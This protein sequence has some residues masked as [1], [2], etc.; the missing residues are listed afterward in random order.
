MSKPTASQKGWLLVKDSLNDI[1]LYRKLKNGYPITITGSEGTPYVLYPNGRFVKIGMKQPELGSIKGSKYVKPDYL[2]TIINWIKYDEK[3]LQ[4]NWECGNF[5][6]NEPL[7]EEQLAYRERRLNAIRYRPRR[8]R[9]SFLSFS[10]LKYLI[11][12]PLFILPFA[13][14]NN[15]SQ[16]TEKTSESLV[17]MTDVIT[18]LLPIIIIIIPFFIII[19]I[20]MKD[21]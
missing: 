15:I 13:L 11:F 16:M 21:W 3:T 19:Q 7:T 5:Q 12:I 1:N 17:N 14:I 4:K 6:V 9:D 18:P 20:I 10:N 8:H 2:A